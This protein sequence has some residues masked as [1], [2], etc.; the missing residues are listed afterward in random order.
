M[1]TRTTTP[2][3][4]RAFRDSRKCG[5]D[6]GDGCDAKWSETFDI[7]FAD[8]TFG[9]EAMASVTVKCEW[10]AQ[11]RNW[12]QKRGAAQDAFTPAAATN[13]SSFYKCTVE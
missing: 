11:G 5:D 12:G 9:C 2:C 6:D 10:D 13:A 7:A 3:V 4:G 1:A 8:G